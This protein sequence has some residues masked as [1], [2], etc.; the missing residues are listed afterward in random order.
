MRRGAPKSS[1]DIASANDCYASI[2]GCGHGT[3]VSGIAAGHNTNRQAGEP[4]SC[5]ARSGGLITIN[6]FSK[7]TNA[8]S[9]NGAPPCILSFNTDQIKGLERVYAL[10]NAFN[11]AAINTSLGGGQKFAP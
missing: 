8:S 3:H 11:I 2:G 1:T 5:V 6:V 10:R 7:F 9:C 4:A